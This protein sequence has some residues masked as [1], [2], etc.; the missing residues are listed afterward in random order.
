MAPSIESLEAEL[1]EMRQLITTV[2]RSSSDQGFVVEFLRN[3]F[4]LENYEQV[5]DTLIKQLANKELE[6]SV[7]ITTEQGRL[8]SKQNQ[9]SE[10]AFDFI[11][12]HRHAGRIVEQSPL[13]LINYDHISLL[14]SNMPED[15]ALQGS[16][17]D[18]LATLLE[19]AD[20][21]VQALHH[22]AHV[23]RLQKSKDEFYMIMSHELK[24]PLNSVIGYATIL[25]RRLQNKVS[26]REL[27][28]LENINDSGQQ[29]LSLIDAILELAR[30]EAGDITIRPSPIDLIQLLARVHNE[31]KDEMKGK[32]LTLE[33]HTTDTNEVVILADI[34]K[35]Q[36]AVEHL[37]DNAQDFTS[38]GG[39]RI[40][41]GTLN[42]DELG[43][44]VS[45][46]IHDTGIGIA[47][48]DQERI[49]AQFTQLDTGVARQSQGTG[50][51]LTLANKLIGLHGGRID[52]NS[53]PS[54]GSTFSIILPLH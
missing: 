51:G 52:V 5:A 9:P 48:E 17:R 38:T 21:K 35:L 19:A 3:S 43:P 54:E 36:S 15:E 37:L 22:K 50:I 28:A 29:L 10:S 49:F 33:L 40:Q 47:S 32:G 16:L 25:Q 26:P 24:T 12:K 53:R 30:H 2:M 8:L 23:S 14:I 31:F 6:A 7:L 11:Y 34:E 1:H 13:C 39:V 18:L 4:T 20:A 45:I 44:S 42:D 46:S 27:T 41:L